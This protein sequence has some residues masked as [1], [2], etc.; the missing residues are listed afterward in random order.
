MGPLAEKQRNNRIAI[1]R[2]LFRILSRTVFGH[3]E[4]RSGHVLNFRHCPSLSLGDVMAVVGGQAIA[5][6]SAKFV[7]VNAS[8][9]AAKFSRKC[10]IDEVPGIRRMLGARWSSQESATCI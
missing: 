3:D 2:V 9:T 4:G 10:K 8:F 5:P 1:K 6:S 7:S